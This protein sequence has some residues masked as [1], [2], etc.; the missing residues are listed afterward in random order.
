VCWLLVVGTDHACG[1]HSNLFTYLSLK[2]DEFTILEERA[3]VW[4][5]QF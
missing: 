3:P 1:L 2:L 4:V 5:L